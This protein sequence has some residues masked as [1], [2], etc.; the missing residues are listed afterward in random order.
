MTKKAGNRKTIF[1]FP[2]FIFVLF[3]VSPVYSDFQVN[4]YTTY[5]Q[6]S[7]SVSRNNNGDFV[8]VWWGFGSNH[9]DTSYDSVQGQRFTSNG[10]FQGSQFQVNTYTTDGQQYPSVNVDNNGDFVVVW[11][12]DGS[13]YGD[14]SYDSIQG[15]RFSSDGSF[16]GSQFQINTYTTDDQ[17]WPA[18]SIDSEGDFVVVWKS[19]GSNYG[20]TNFYS[21]QGQRFASDG[22]FMGSQFQINTYTTSN[23]RIPSISVD[24]AGDFVVV[25]RSYGSNYGDTSSFSIQGQRFASNGSFQGSQFQVNTYTTNIQYSSAVSRNTNGDFVVVWRSYGSNYGDTSFDS[26]QGQ[27]FASDG[28]FL[29]SQFQVNTYTTHYQQIPSVSVNSEGDFVVVW[30][31]FGS[32]YG[33][34]FSYSIQGQRYSSDGSFLGSQFQVN[35]YTTLYQRVPSVS[36][37]SDGDFVVVWQSWGSNYG[38]TSGY[39][40]QG[41]Q[42]EQPNA[43]PT[44]NHTFTIILFI[45]LGILVVMKN[46]G[47]LLQQKFNKIKQKLTQDAK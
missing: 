39:S 11:T 43:V 13:N 37:N 10:S 46:K 5:M 21:I 16:Q 8:V 26:I 34:E 1:P 33:D 42:F 40:I 28:S 41:R 36:S 23:Q 4:T 19:Y 32:N 9:G 30:D 38:D 31:S 35:T 7:S 15:Q 22:S 3:V 14:T 17:H 47:L 45:L 44:L 6:Y 18:V 12:S 25:W 20:D 29:G 24:S 27:R 2:L